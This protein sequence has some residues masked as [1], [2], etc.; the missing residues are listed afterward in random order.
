MNRSATSPRRA[1]RILIRAAIGLLAVLLAAC[2]AGASAGPTKLVVGLGYI[3]SVQFA[4]FYYAD[5]A[6]YYS[7]AGLQVEFQN[8]IDPELIILVGQGGVDIGVADGTSVIPAV[9]QAIPIKY[10]YTVY[11]EFPNVIVAKASSGIT[12][13]ADLKGKRIGIPGKFGSSW[14]HLE[15]LLADANLTAND[16]QLV[17]FPD[18]GQLAALEKDAVDA[19]A[20]Y[21]NNEPVRLQQEGIAPVA[22]ALPDDKQLPGPGLIVGD[23]TLASKRAAVVAFAS[24]TRRAMEEIAADPKKGLDA[25]VARV[26]ELASQRDAQLAV[27]Q[28]TISQW[29]SDYTRA[30]GTGAVDQALWDRSIAFM[31]SL[32]DKVVAKPITSTG[33][34]VTGFLPKA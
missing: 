23:K 11:A 26:P 22:L 24:A 4:Q 19:A 3:P 16:V 7:A 13:A 15:A 20:G 31:S 12:S 27:L 30:N 18:F 5:Q 14:I 6:G 1:P 2:N 10:V 33:C 25:S 32:P 29:Q 8:K 9:S 21:A 17:L 34:I 28:A